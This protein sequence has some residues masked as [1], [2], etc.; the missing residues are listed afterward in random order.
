[1]QG[2]FH[3]YAW[4]ARSEKTTNQ[5]K[6]DR[7]KTYLGRDPDKQSVIGGVWRGTP[8]RAR[9]DLDKTS[10]WKGILAPKGL[11]HSA[12]GGGGGEKC[13]EKGGIS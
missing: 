7:G 13:L 3:T 2:A 1:V 4:K 10:K 8:S 11:D 6:N 5:T 12:D 9:R